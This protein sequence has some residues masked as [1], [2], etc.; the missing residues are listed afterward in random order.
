[1]PYLIWSCSLPFLHIYSSHSICPLPL[2]PSSPLISPICLAVLSSLLPLSPSS[3][4][5]PLWLSLPNFPLT[6]HLIWLTSLYSSL[7]RVTVWLPAPFG[8]DSSNRG[9]GAG[10]AD[11]RASAPWRCA[12]HSA[13]H[14]PTGRTAGRPTQEPHPRGQGQR[15]PQ[16]H[17]GNAA[18]DTGQFILIS[19]FLAG[20]GKWQKSK[21]DEGEKRLKIGGTLSSSQ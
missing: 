16:P 13:G 5:H 20:T 21:R 19:D 4:S 8:R 10:G 6:S 18:S 2:C 11:Q 3:S 12:I 14:G 7:H 1:M 17:Q 9:Q 15:C